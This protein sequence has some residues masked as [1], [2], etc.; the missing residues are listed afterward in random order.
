[1][2]R[3]FPGYARLVLATSILA[4]TLGASFGVAA[5]D[6]P[7]KE[8]RIVTEGGF[9]PWNYTKPDGTLAGLSLIH[10]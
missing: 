9:V 6:A 1:M 4:A 2:T 7:P 5:E 3:S 8:I 10:I